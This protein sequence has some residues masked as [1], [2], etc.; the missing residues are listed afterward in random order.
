MK[1]VKDKNI[2]L[3]EIKNNPNDYIIVLKNFGDNYSRL[4]N[5]IYIL[6]KEEE[7]YRFRD[8]LS[9]RKWVA[10]RELEV[11]FNDINIDDLY[12]FEDYISFAKWL[13]NIS[14]LQKY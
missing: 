7:V 5:R 12:A 14:V 2:C 10:F 4:E 13:N 1:V 9:N 11:L 3:S 6:N 8:I